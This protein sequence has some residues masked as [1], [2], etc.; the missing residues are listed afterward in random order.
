MNR[1]PK[2]AYQYKASK[3]FW[4]KYWELPSAQKQSVLRQW[5]YFKTN[6]FDSRLGTH[7]I[8]ALSARANK[9]IYSVVIENDLRALFYLEDNTVF[10]FDIGSH[11]I[12]Q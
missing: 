6:P 10:T 11:K 9:T 5:Q 3:T 1:I 7:K 4:K 2:V 12:Y 8:N